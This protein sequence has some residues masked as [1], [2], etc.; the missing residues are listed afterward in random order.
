VKKCLLALAIAVLFACPGKQGCGPGG[1]SG[2]GGEIDPNAAFES[3]MSWDSGAAVYEPIAEI[4]ERLGAAACEFARRCGRIDSTEPCTAPGFVSQRLATPLRLNRVRVNEA[5]IEACVNALKASKNCNLPT[6]P[7]CDEQENSFTTP[8][9]EQGGLCSSVDQCQLDDYCA[10]A[11]TP[12]SDTDTCELGRCAARTPIG[13]T[14]PNFGSCTRDAYL[15][16]QNVC[17]ARVAR[18][19][20]CDQSAAPLGEQLCLEPSDFCDNGFCRPFFAWGDGANG[21]VC[22]SDLV[23]CGFGLQCIRNVCVGPGGLG[24]ACG[25]PEDAVCRTGLY[26]DRGTKRCAKKRNQGEACTDEFECLAGLHCGTSGVAG[27]VA[28]CRALSRG[29][30][31]CLFFAASPA[32]PP[33]GQCAEVARCWQGICRAIRS[34]DEPCAIIY[35]PNYATTCDFGLVCDP[36]SLR[37][38]PKVCEP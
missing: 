27:D 10:F 25:A 30:E 29:G 20:A 5:S 36:Q 14:T 13:G 23:S 12:G 31:P 8:T 17:T 3:A 35:T 22:N 16:R 4:N 21:E 1:T 37:C 18:N 6:P 24:T 7:E 33:L 28:S 9:V 11:T 38:V 15:N 34:L 32:L 26:C 2:P 19:Q